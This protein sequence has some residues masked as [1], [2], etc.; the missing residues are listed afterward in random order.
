[1]EDY[2]VD[3]YDITLTWEDIWKHPIMT[4][5]GPITADGLLN[6][7]TIQ[8]S[9]TAQVIKKAT[10]DSVLVHDAVISRFGDGK[11]ILYN[12]PGI[13]TVEAYENVLEGQKVGV[14]NAEQFAT[15]LKLEK[16]SVLLSITDEA[17]IRSEAR[18]ISAWEWQKEQAA[19]KL[20]AMQDLK[21]VHQLD[22]T[23]Q[24]GT[25]IN[26]SSGNI[27][28]ALAEAEEKISDY[29]ITAIVCSKAARTLIMKNVNAQ[30]YTGSNP[31]A[32]Y[33]GT[34]L[35]GYDI[36][37]FATNAVTAVDSDSIYF[38]SSQVPGCIWSPG[39]V[40]THTW[41][42]EEGGKVNMRIDAFRAAKSNVLQTP[43]NY[44]LGVVET[45]WTAS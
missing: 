16:D 28:S 17:I 24:T 32:P 26:L 12:I 41:R 7:R 29:D 43:D 20:A 11:D 27:Y 4:N 40:L 45:T 37:I 21:I 15:E 39:Q 30:G 5:I 18:G 36:P 25:P 42:D 31:A 34:F 22:T 44:N 3:G 35:P 10:G 8:A 23:P 14:T 38:V 13:G 6:S 33:N 19:K 2:D 1:M 9:Q